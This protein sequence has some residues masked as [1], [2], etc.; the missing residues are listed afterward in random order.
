MRYSRSLAGLPSKND[1]EGWTT[2]AQAFAQRAGFPGCV[3]AGDG[4]L[5][6]IYYQTGTDGT[7]Y[8]SR[9]GFYALN[10][11]VV[12]DASMRFMYVGGG[13]PGTVYDGHC[14]ERTSFGQRLARGDVLPE[15]DT[16]FYFIVDG[17][18][19]VSGG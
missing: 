9:K 8:F 1:V 3:G 2:I 14:W 17:G 16:S 12:V 15:G 7:I 18:Y 13:L 10:F 19:V 6:P 11:Q 5:L 4:V